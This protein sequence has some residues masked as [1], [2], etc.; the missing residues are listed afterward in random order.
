MTAPNGSWRG[1]RFTPDDVLFFRDGRP[2]T[3]GADHYLP[4]LFP[5]HPSTLYGAL[6]SRRLLDAGFSPARLRRER[7]RAWEMLPEDVQVEI[8][9]WG[10]FGSLALRGPWL[11]RRRND[12]ADRE[13]LLPAP[14]DLALT[15]SESGPATTGRH[16]GHEAIRAKRVFRFRGAD[17]GAGGHSHSLRLLEPYRLSGDGWQRWTESKPPPSA[18]GWFLTAA[19][20]RIWAE[21][22]APRPADLVHASELWV[23]EPRVGV[24]I[25]AQRRVATEGE[26][27]TFG[28]IRLRPG[29]D[30][31]F[32][33]RGTALAPGRRVR[34][35]GEGRTGWID[36]APALASLQLPHRPSSSLRLAVVSPMV[37]EAGTYPPGFDP[38]RGEV[39]IAG[40][41]FR[42]EAAQVPGHGTV[43]GWDL[44]RGAAK[45]LRRTVPAGSVFVV[46][47]T[48]GGLVDPSELHGLRLA[49]YPGESLALQGFGLVVAGTDPDAH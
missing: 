24:G 46:A 49:G 3:R 5:P 1:F 4:S 44:A 22:G 8:G 26:L 12:G 21:G 20:L 37:S 14:A 45:P 25:E 6:R 29:V 10:G 17:L 13:V 2:S 30:L 43:G 18:R 41:P 34:L 47:P 48:D 31:G 11:V 28:F 19:G 15:H 32:E 38:K 7:Q 36:E 27:F 39:K 33:V 16:R 40:R 9:P 23:N 35:G 42:I